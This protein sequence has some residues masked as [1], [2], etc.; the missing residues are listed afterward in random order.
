LI[1]R[2]II[3]ICQDP[4]RPARSRRGNP[5]SGPRTE[6]P[7]SKERNHG[8]D[9]ADLAHGLFRILE[10][11]DPALALDVVAPDNYNWEAFVAPAACAI[12]GPAGT[13]AS[14]VWHSAGSSGLV[15]RG[16]GV[17][18]VGG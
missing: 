9:A 11:G 17:L 5:G 15:G 12:A 10:T 6:E 16:G 2:L 1:R 13:L 3:P 4:A 7:P 14:G 18:G 8:T